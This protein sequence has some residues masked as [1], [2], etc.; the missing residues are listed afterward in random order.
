MVFRH[1]VSRTKT[2]LFGCLQ[3]LQTVCTTASNVALFTPVSI[4]NFAPRQSGGEFIGLYASHPEPNVIDKFDRHLIVMF[5]I[6]GS[7][8]SELFLIAANIYGDSTGSA[9]VARQYGTG[10]LD[11]AFSTC[12][13]H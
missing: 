10:L 3:R 6:R 13:S 11:R 2:L 9:T 7:L 1:L 8:S 5:F 4:K 12:C